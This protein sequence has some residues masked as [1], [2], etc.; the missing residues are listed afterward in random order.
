MNDFIII[1]DIDDPGRGISVYGPFCTRDDASTYL[2]KHFITGYIEQLKKNTDLNCEISYC[3][4][5]AV[6]ICD[7][8]E[9]NICNF[10]M[11]QVCDQCL[12][13]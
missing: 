13:K 9:R 2:K 8:C 11:K 5:E 7:F 4:S 1:A 12:K 6:A 10:C 3:K